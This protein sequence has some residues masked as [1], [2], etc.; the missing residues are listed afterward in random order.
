MGAGA[1]IF[2][3]YSARILSSSLHLEI[4]ELRFAQKIISFVCVWVVVGIN[5]LGTRLATRVNAVCAVA[6]LIAIGSIAIFGIGSLGSS[7]G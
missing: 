4:V 2:G 3:E 6:K 5:V 1:I 7:H